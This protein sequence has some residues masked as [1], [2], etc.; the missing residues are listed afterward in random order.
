MWYPIHFPKIQGVITQGQLNGTMNQLESIVANLQIPVM[1]F[2]VWI[3][4]K[5]VKGVNGKQ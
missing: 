2:H 3:K 5:R 1:R 4:F